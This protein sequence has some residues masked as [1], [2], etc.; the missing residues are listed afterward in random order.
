MKGK[1]CSF[2]AFGITAVLFG[3]VAIACTLDSGNN[4]NSSS[5]ILA[6]S[7]VTATALSKSSIKISWVEAANDATRHYNVYRRTMASGFDK[8][9]DKRASNVDKV[10]Y[11]DE[12]GL[13]PGTQY[14]Y[15]ITAVDKE[16]IESNFSEVVWAYTFDEAG[17][18]VTQHTITFDAD[19]GT[20]ATQTKTVG[21]D[22]ILASLPT[23]PTKSGYNFGGWFS[24][25][26]G[27]GPQ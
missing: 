26:I 19:G 18:P 11:V 7:G 12:V 2:P 23:A 3:V 16:G 10:F 20:P 13:S 15:R 25:K 5:G 22:N 8:D 6:P 24:G 17:K 21:A 4:G 14:F 27:A 9:T 1:R